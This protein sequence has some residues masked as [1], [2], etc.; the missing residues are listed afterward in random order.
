[1]PSNTDQ[2]IPLNSA[3]AQSTTLLSVSTTSFDLEQG[4][5]TWLETPKLT[6]LELSIIVPR[7]HPEIE[8]QEEEFPPD[9]A[10]T[11]SPRRNSAEVERLE[12]EAQQALKEY[13]D[14]QSLVPS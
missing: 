3:V 5:L 13:A 4:R 12:L 2:A 11:M 1:M 10:R 7:D 6:G 9:D 8:I 14:Q